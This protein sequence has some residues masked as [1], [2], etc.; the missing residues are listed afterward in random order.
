MVYRESGSMKQQ[1]ITLIELMVVVAIIGIIAAVAYPSYQSF[2]EKSRRADGQ[3]TLM[4]FAGAMERYYTSN[5]TYC[6]AGPGTGCTSGAPDAAVFADEAPL[7]GNDKYYDLR[8][9]ALGQTSFTL[10]ATPK[11]AQA[12]D[13]C[14][15]LTLSHTG[16]RGVSNAT[17]SVNEC[18]Q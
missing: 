8:I 15:I 1:G 18:W 6:G 4:A 10:S 11:N 3:S 17:Y 2:M 5:D 13:P 12:N 7:D 9:A 16:A 14:N